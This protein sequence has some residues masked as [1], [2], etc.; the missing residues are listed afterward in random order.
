MKSAKWLLWICI[1]RILIAGGIFAQENKKSFDTGH[2]ITLGSYNEFNSVS[3]R[4]L[5]DIGYDYVFSTAY[6]T[7]TYNLFDLGIGLSALFVWDDI[8]RFEVPTVGFAVE[9]PVRI[10]APLIKGA[11]LFVGTDIRMIMYTEEYPTNGTMFNVGWRVGPG[12]DYELDNGVRLFGTLGW[13]HTSNANIYGKERN[14][15][16][17]GIGTSFGIQYE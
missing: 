8:G 1:L 15:S 5:M 12:M 6:L 17:N 3:K 4:G 16:V 13:W 2:R 11:R 14:P 7:P 10:Y 9:L